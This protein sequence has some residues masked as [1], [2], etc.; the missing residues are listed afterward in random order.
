MALIYQTSVACFDSNSW[1]V[2]IVPL[3]EGYN[4]A[5]LGR[6][7]SKPWHPGVNSVGKSMFTSQTIWFIE[8]RNIG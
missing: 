4:L 6:G 2:F 8:F 5:H 7:P 1:K 3:L